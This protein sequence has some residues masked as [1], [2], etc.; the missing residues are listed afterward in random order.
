MAL[1]Y[2]WTESLIMHCAHK[3]E[4]WNTLIMDWGCVVVC[5]GCDEGDRPGMLLRLRK[6]ERER[7]REKERERARCDNDVVTTG[8]K[9][10]RTLLYW[11]SLSFAAE[12]PTGNCSC[13]KTVVNPWRGRVNNRACKCWLQ[14]ERHAWR[15]IATCKTGSQAWFTVYTCVFT[16]YTRRTTSHHAA[17]WRALLRST[18]RIKSHQFAPIEQ[19]SIFCA[20]PRDFAAARLPLQ[21]KLGLFNV[22]GQKGLS[23]TFVQTNG[24]CYPSSSS[25]F[26]TSFVVFLVKTALLFFK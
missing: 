22:L 9:C 23:K 7:E 24:F 8:P 3:I 4:Y 13:C 21:A 26:C 5:E 12:R 25:S 14:A 6:T 2:G 18:V 10:T 15:R 11:S 1:G 20:R 16:I 17:P 19:C